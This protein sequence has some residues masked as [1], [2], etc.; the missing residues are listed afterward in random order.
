[1][2]CSATRKSLF[3]PVV[4]D[5]PERW[6][7]HSGIEKF[8]HWKPNCYLYCNLDVHPKAYESFWL[9]LLHSLPC[10]ERLHRRGHPDVKECCCPLHA[11]GG[12]PETIEHVV[13][14]SSI[15]PVWS[16]LF[17]TLARL[18][19]LD[20]ILSDAVLFAETDAELMWRMLKEWQSC[21]PAKMQTMWRGMMV[22]M[23]DCIVRRRNKLSIDKVQVT[24]AEEHRR[25]CKAII[26]EF[27][28]IWSRVVFHK[29]QKVIRS[30][31][32]LRT[33]S[34][35]QKYYEKKAE[36][37]TTFLA[38]S[39]WGHLDPGLSSFENTFIKSK[40]YTILY[41]RYFKLTHKFKLSRSSW[42]GRTRSSDHNPD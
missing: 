17:F 6:A 16:W 18:T 34:D 33:N 26:E 30:T 10:K 3:K 39:I 7:K 32:S 37:E 1:M 28:N 20:P 35:I 23:V 5:A 2:T 41:P 13:F 11:P 29:A 40:R 4:S 38:R 15:R 19:T 12:P 36:L 22:S 42:A 21:A 31:K 27:T 8:K 9:I 25:N 24:K 14:C